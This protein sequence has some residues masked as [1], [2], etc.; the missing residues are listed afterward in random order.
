MARPRNNPEEPIVKYFVVGQSS[1]NV[2]QDNAPAFS[3]T[4]NKFE[5][6]MKWLDTNVWT[7]ASKVQMVKRFYEVMNRIDPY[8]FSC[9]KHLHGGYNFVL[10]GNE[11]AGPNGKAITS[12]AANLDRVR[13]NLICSL[14]AKEASVGANGKASKKL[15]E[16]RTPEQFLDK[17]DEIELSLD[18]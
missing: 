9:E 4:H 8:N 10:P 5:G 14:L 6:I 17:L 1:F 16:Y 12:N 15:I 11:T 13:F 18:I 7:D 3:L 2:R